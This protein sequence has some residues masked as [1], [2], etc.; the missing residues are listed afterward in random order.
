VPLLKSWIFSFTL[1]ELEP[2]PVATAPLDDVRLDEASP[3]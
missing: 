2:S 1:D 3:L